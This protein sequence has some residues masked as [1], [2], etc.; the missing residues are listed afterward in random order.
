MPRPEV[1]GRH[2]AAEDDQLSAIDDPYL[3]SNAVKRRYGDCSDMWLHR[4]LNDDSGFPPPDLVVNGRRFWK[5]SSLACWER[6]RARAGRP[7]SA[8]RGRGRNTARAAGN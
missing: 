7:S 4:R 5:L 6:E 8:G 1:T 2:S 3:N